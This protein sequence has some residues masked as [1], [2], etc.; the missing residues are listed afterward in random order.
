MMKIEKPFSQY[1]LYY[2]AIYSDKNYE[3]ECDF[4][5]FVFRKY[6]R[7]TPKKILDAG[8]GTGNHLIPMAKR[9][10]TLTGIDL[11]KEM[12]SIAKERR[13]RLASAR[14]NELKI[15]LKRADIRNFDLGGG[16]TF[17]ACICMFAVLGYVT[18]T[19][20]VLSAFS[21]V[22]KHLRK[23][24]LFIFDVWYGPAVL[25]IGPTPRLKR[26]ENNGVRI[27]RFAQPSLLKKENICKVNYDFLVLKGKRVLLEYQELH[28]VR[29][30][31]KDE[32]RRLLH[33]AGFQLLEVG[34]FPGFH[35]KPSKQTWEIAVVARA[36]S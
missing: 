20:E 22:R 27:Y 24:G 8:C 13:R 3:E 11:S 10:Y 34:A 18:K 12:L 6:S 15:E 23:G 17:D 4:L 25:H 35:S 29:Y 5:E 19:A 26:V 9:G 33:K 21:S 32:L 1:A 14:N 36:T 30:Y 31:Y 2:N 7:D 28:T 16:E